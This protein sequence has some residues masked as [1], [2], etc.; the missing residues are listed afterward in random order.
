MLKQII[1]FCCV[2][3]SNDKADIYEK[4]N[5]SRI[6]TIYEIIVAKLHF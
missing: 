1:L 4:L 6:V 3:T 5:S 2:K